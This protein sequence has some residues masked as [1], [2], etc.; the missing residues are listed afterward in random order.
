MTHYLKAWEYSVA[1]DLMLEQER[2]SHANTLITLGQRVWLFNISPDK[3]INNL[4]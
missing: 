2:T 3:H 4:H 1:M